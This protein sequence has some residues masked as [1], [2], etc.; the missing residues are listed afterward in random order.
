MLWIPG[1]RYTMGSNQGASDE[2]PEHIVELGP[3]WM[4][5]T[6]VTN[7][8]FERFVKSTGYVTLAERSPDPK[9]FPDAPPENLV[10]GS[11]VFTPSAEIISFENPLAWWRWQPGANWKHPEGPDS[12]LAGR[13]RHPVVH[14]CW[15]DASAYAKWAGKRLPTEAEWEY[16]ARGGLL[17]QPY[18]WGTEAPLPIHANIWQGK[19][20]QLDTAADGWRGTAPVGSYPPNGFGLVDMAG[21]VWEWCSDWYRPDTYANSPA[22]NPRGPADSYDPQEPGMPKKVMRGGSFLC[23]DVYCGGYRPS[24]RMKSSPDTGLGHTGFRCVQD[25]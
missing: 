25:P 16:A 5:R 14:V 17:G 21:N 24:T 8:A 22:Q 19:F 12:N 4:D 20:P 23:N 15:E 11:G 7:E 13:E 18:V 1:G 2:R 6:E 3:F 9:Q 10:A